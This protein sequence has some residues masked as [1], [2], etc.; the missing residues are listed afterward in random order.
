MNIFIV[1]GMLDA[2]TFVRY[3]ASIEL[4]SPLARDLSLLGLG[5]LPRDLRTWALMKTLII[6]RL[7]ARERDE[8]APFSPDEERLTMDDIAYILSCAGVCYSKHELFAQ[9]AH[10]ARLEKVLA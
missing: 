5:Y 2:D 9:M 4:K 6:E 10:R 1:L 7:S 8:G 3:R